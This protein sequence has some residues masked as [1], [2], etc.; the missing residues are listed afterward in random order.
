MASL[1]KPCTPTS[2]EFIPVGHVAL[3]RH[4][5]EDAQLGLPP[6]GV[7][8]INNLY[9]SWA[10][11]RSGLGGAA[12]KELERMVAQP[13]LDGEYMVLDAIPEEFQFSPEV[14]ERQYLSRGLTPPVVSALG[15]FL[16]ALFPPPLLFEDG[17]NADA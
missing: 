2:K 12:M 1:G 8:W 11:Q 15:L 17:R 4:P 14:L 16:L 6:T 5:E 3:V 13:P 7:F 9:I 10:L